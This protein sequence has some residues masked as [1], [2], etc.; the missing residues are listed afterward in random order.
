VK[1]QFSTS[2]PGRF[3]KVVILH[4]SDER[5]LSP[6]LSPI[7]DGREGEPSGCV[8]KTGRC[9]FSAALG[10]NE[11][12]HQVQKFKA[13]MFHSGSFLAIERRGRRLQRAAATD[14]SEDFA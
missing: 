2:K 4:K 10:Q 11:R 1:R 14:F 3:G 9:G 13:R 12:A 5:L 6:S 7:G 8:G